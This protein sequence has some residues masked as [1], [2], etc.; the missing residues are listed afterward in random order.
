MG[1]PLEQSKNYWTAVRRNIRKVQQLW[2]RL[3]VI[4][5]WEG[6]EPITSAVFYRVVVQEVLLFGAE[7]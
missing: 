7:T 2:L 4:L 1:W 6:V 5:R 3:G